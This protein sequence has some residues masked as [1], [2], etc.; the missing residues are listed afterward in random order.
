MADRKQINPRRPI[1]TSGYNRLRENL[2]SGFAEGF[3]IEEFPNPDNR[4]NLSRGRITTRKDDRF[5][6]S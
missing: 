3:P 4:P 1:P 5:T 6:R 2:E